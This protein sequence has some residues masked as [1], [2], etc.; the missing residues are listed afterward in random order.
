MKNDVILNKIN[1]IERCMN[2]VKVVYAN[3]PENL[4][5]F[6]KQD[7][8]ILNI[9][10]ACES[11]IDLAMHIVAD[12]RLGLP[13]S[14][15]DAFDMLQ[16]HS[17]IDEDTAKRLK[18]MVGFRNI[19]VNDYQTINLDILKQIV[20]NHLSDFTVFTKQVLNFQ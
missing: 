18:A 11:S 9:Q 3:N 4:K 17:V 14:S 8:I 5:D 13:Q 16:E 10:R 2:R 20:V 7:S 15:R 12:Q 1:A 19:A 6:T